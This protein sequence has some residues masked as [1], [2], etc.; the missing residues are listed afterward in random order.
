MKDALCLMAMFIVGCSLGAQNLLS[1]DY[2]A[3]AITPIIDD[4]I[5]HP[6]VMLAKNG[7]YYLTGTQG[8]KNWEKENTS[9]SLWQS[10]DLKQWENSGEI[11][12]ITKHEA[13]KLPK[14][15]LPDTYHS[16]K[17]VAFRA[18]EIA[19]IGQDFYLIYAQ[20]TGGICL[21]KSQTQKAEGPYRAHAVLRSY[22][23]DPSLFQDDD[24]KVYL[25]FNG[26]FVGLLNDDLN[27]LAEH[28]RFIYPEIESKKGW[29]LPP[30]LDR[31][32]TYGAK[33]FKLNG[34]YCISAGDAHWR[35]STYCHDLFISQSEGDIYGPYHRRYMA[36]PHAANACVF[37]GKNGQWWSTYSGNPDDA[38]ALFSGKTG[39]IPMA[40]VNKG[41]NKVLLPSPKVIM[42]KGPTASC[43]PVKDL[44]DQFARDPSI[45]IGHDN[46]YYMV[47]TIGPESRGPHGGIK[48]WRSEDLHNWE[49]LGYVWTWKKDSPQWLKDR[50]MNDNL[51]APEISFINN[52]YYIAISLSKVPRC[53][54]LLQ[55][56][57]NNPTGKYND[58]VGHKIA[59]GIDG[60]LFEDVDKTVYFLWGNGHIA[61]MK[62]DMSGFATEPWHIKDKDGLS[63]GYEGVGIIRHKGKYIIH[64]ADHS[65]DHSGSYDMTYVVADHIKGPYSERTVTL[66]HVGH[67]TIFKGK[68]GKWY[69]SIFGSTGNYAFYNR[70][71][72]LELEISDDFQFKVRDTRIGY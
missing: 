29:G 14:T 36:V 45:C 16:Q 25:A 52:R 51:W 23:Y 3:Q 50:N 18:P 15:G 57:K 49:N 5:Q 48:M 54:M 6:N 41:D 68:D 8:G 31:I 28:P 26:G 59:D 32:G 72:L 44:K 13:F 35:L 63:L 67:T 39:I 2:D 30:T 12:N 4:S 61:P 20:T 7:Y 64:A 55:S 65:G 22:G 37:E 70:F 1:T 17:V 40:E 46:A 71:G 21:C 43:H 19:Q 62:K 11:W 10:K 27:A 69:C 42:E 60:Y 38:Y 34:K 9:I 47:C 24:G 33:I 56:P 53:V 66:P 58:P